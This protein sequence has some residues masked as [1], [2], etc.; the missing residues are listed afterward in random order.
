VKAVRGLAAE[1]SP[2]GIYEATEVSAG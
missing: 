1:V 2:I